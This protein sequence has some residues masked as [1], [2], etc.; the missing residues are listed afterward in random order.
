MQDLITSMSKQA[1]PQKILS[2]AE[3]IEGMLA[4]ESSAFEMTVALHHQRMLTI[5]KAIIGEAFAEEIV[6]DAWLSAIR[7]LGEFAGRSSLQTWLIQ[8]TANAAKTRLRRE[9]RQVS[10]DENWQQ[11]ES[12]ERFDH[13]GHWREH[14][15]QWDIDTPE[16]IVANHQLSEIIHQ[17][18]EQLPP[19]QQAIL[20]LYD[21]QGETMPEICN[22]LGISASN[23]RVLLHR[24]RSAIHQQI[25]HYQENN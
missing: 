16:A 25:H 24:A 12:D 17:A 19:Q 18:F 13:T 22:I 3:L 14:I 6:Q 20:T 11:S 1:E 5:A 10:L 9:K 21:L 7:S 15:S 2:D 23:A 8:I 4:G